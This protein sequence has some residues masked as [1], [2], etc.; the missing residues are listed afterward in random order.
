[1]NQYCLQNDDNACH[2]PDRMHVFFNY[3]MFPELWEE[4]VF[5]NFFVALLS[6]LSMLNGLFYIE[7]VGPVRDGLVC[8][9]F[10]CYTKLSLLPREAEGAYH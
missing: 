9:I 7:L 1:M 4:L 5:W 10:A 6:W 8:G 3:Q 2:C